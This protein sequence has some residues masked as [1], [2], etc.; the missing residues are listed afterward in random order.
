MT[1]RG[2]SVF[3]TDLRSRFPRPAISG[4]VALSPG[5]ILCIKRAG[6]GVRNRCAVL[7]ARS[8]LF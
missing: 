8:T 4:P 2:S 5:V 7:A 3:A 6:K 1:K